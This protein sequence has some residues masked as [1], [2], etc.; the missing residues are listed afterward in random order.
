MES[1]TLLLLEHDRLQ[2]YK[3]GVLT[4]SSASELKTITSGALIPLSLLDIHTIKLSDRLSDED[5]Q[6]QVEI[7]MFEEGNLNSDEE[8]TIDFIRHSI[9]N[10]SDAL[11]EAFAL[12]HTKANDYFQEVLSKTSVIDRIVPGFM[13]YSA[14]YP[15]LSPK[16]DLF[17]YWGEEEAYAAIYQEGRYIAHRS[18]ETL[19]SIAV[20]T[21]FEL[22]KLK[23]ILQTKGVIEENYLPEELNKFILIQERI[24]KNIERIVHTI[25]HKRGLF[26]LSGIDNCYLDF[27]GKT[28]VGLENVFNAYGI[29]DLTLLP[30]EREGSAPH[31]IH[32]VLCAEYFAT[33][34]TRFNLSPYSRKAPWYT[35]E[36]GKFLSIV[37]G[38][39]L[40]M[41]IASGTVGW[42]SANEQARTEELTAQLETLKK[43][44]AQ[45]SEILKKN[46]TQLKEQQGKN[47]TIREDIA[48]YHGAEETALL[49]DDIHFQRQHF[50]TDTTAELGKYRLGAQMV[51]QNS[52]KEMTIHVVADYR[53]RDDIAK[54]MS[55]LYERGYQNVE[56]HEI[57]LDNNNTTY[58]SLVKV[59]R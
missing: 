23:Q 47:H 50:L 45:L 10:D 40:I 15:A 56:T 59:T 28:I 29:S 9:S 31:D 55:G 44:T 27:E 51:E 42:M 30:L 14:L 8:Y 25:N 33:S 17:I 36:S 5:M 53:K 3:E 52:S 20:E 38:A 11:V 34:D 12:S 57:K 48:L 46:T 22:S 19:T 2:T 18:I 32:R 37:G 13:V 39:L 6:I 26:G 7:R 35:R 21:G 1:P 43:E 49:I 41:L 4:E 54:L 16:N 58:N 24:A